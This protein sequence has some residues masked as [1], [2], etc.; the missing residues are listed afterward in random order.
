MA[1]RGRS[2]VIA[3]AGL[4]GRGQG[5]ALVPDSDCQ[6]SVS[7]RPVIDPI[8]LSVYL[9]V[10]HANP[11]AIRRSSSTSLIA[12]IPLAVKL[13]PVGLGTGAVARGV[14]AR[15]QRG[16]EEPN[17]AY[18]RNVAPEVLPAGAKTSA[19]QAEGPPKHLKVSI[20]M[21]VGLTSSVALRRAMRGRPTRAAAAPAKVVASAVP[22]EAAPEAKQGPLVDRQAFGEAFGTVAAG[23]NT[24]ALS[25]T[26][27]EEPH[28]ELEPGRAEESE[29]E[30]LQ[31]A[32]DQESM[33]DGLQP[34][35]KGYVSRRRASYEA[36]L[37]V[38]S[39]TGSRCANNVQFVRTASWE[40]RQPSE[41]KTTDLHRVEFHRM[42][43][44]PLKEDEAD[45][46]EAPN[47]YETSFSSF[48][49]TG[50]QTPW[51]RIDTER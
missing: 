37:Q 11:P 6:G 30:Q 17:E 18:D 20:A 28:P 38:E 10:P 1:P 24:Q 4:V 8:T 32:S 47:D 26:G 39:K 44:E 15:L 40:K 22:A 16:K 41:R 23:L 42:S 45:A 43:T 14:L 3:A 27:D 25:E 48:A 35:N 49:G 9:D 7:L 13:L 33:D 21:L 36:K 12:P 29:Q 19:R 51:F 5:L 2:L 31:D 46:E 50:G 34:G